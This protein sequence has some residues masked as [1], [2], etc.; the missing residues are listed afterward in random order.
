M[1]HRVAV[2]G[3]RIH[4]GYF[5][6]YGY[7][8]R[9][10]DQREGSERARRGGDVQGI[11]RGRE[12]VSAAQGCDGDAAD[13]SSGRNTSQSPYFRGSVGVVD[14]AT[15]SSPVGGSRGRSVAGAGDASIVHGA[16]G[17]VSF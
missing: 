12:W 4:S 8:T 7:S 10:R 2:H 1:I 13:L 5:T 17:E 16:T 14:S 6:A 3:L 11:E 15:A 9:H